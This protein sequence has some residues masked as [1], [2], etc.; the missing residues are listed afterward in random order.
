VPNRQLDNGES[1]KAA[2]LLGRVRRELDLLSGGD[3]NLLFAYRRKLYKELTYDERGK[4][5][6]RRIL[7]TQKLVQQDCKCANP[8]CPHADLRS[9]EVH[10]HRLEAALGYTIE[11]TELLCRDCH[12]KQ[13]ADRGYT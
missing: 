9:V 11:N 7:K 4:P 8:E 12:I 6:E 1:K 3:A 5:T 13:Q 2:E 10:L